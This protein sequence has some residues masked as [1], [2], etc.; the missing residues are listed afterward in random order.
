VAEGRQ[1]FEKKAAFSLESKTV[2]FWQGQKE[3]V[4]EVCTA[5]AARTRGMAPQVKT[6]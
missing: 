2:S 1:D 4:L 5:L 6:A 3:M